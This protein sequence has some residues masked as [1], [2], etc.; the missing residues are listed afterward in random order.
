MPNQHAY[1]LKSLA[2]Q[3]TPP[4][5]ASAIAMLQELLYSHIWCRSQADMY[6]IFAYALFSHGEH[7]C[8]FRSAENTAE[9]WLGAT[10]VLCSVTAFCVTTQSGN[11]AHDGRMFWWQRSSY[12]HALTSTIP[13]KHSSACKGRETEAACQTHHAKQK[14]HHATQ[15]FLHDKNAWLHSICCLHLHAS[16]LCNVNDILHD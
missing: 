11:S 9:I 13:A 1:T 8:C 16:L 14:L 3:I 4:I 2:T 12:L 10:G 6:L 15:H 7:L 5:L